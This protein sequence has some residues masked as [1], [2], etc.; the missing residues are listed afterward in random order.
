V[1]LVDLLRERAADFSTCRIREARQLCQMFID[2]M[3]C[4]RSLARRADEQRALLGRRQSD[5]IT[6]DDTPRL[7]SERLEGIVSAAFIELTVE[8]AHE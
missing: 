3:P 8:R 2:L 4:G 7:R 5:R 6:R 1:R